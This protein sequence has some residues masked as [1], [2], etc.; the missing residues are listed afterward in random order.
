MTMMT[1]RVHADG[2]LRDG[3]D[4]D[5]G[6]DLDDGGGGGGSCGDCCDTGMVFDVVA[7][8]SSPCAT[9]HREP[10]VD[11]RVVH[12]ERTTAE[13]SDGGIR[14]SRPL[15]APPVGEGAASAAVALEDLR[16]AVE[17]ARGESTSPFQ[18]DADVAADG[19]RV[20]NPL[21]AL[22]DCA[23]E[24]LE[25]ERRFGEA[26]CAVMRG[27]SPADARLHE[28]AHRVAF[29]EVALR[30]AASAGRAIDAA[31]AVAADPA[32]CVEVDGVHVS[33]ADG[34]GVGRR[35]HVSW[36]GRIWSRSRVDSVRSGG[37]LA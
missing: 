22:A 1:T 19:H 3:V 23:I 6:I 13:G 36:W 18:D 25:A 27:V 35:R 8:T 9:C 32:P 11:P 30:T 14:P 31:V 37:D 4:G 17:R 2:G 21:V 12:W 33:G 24:Y 20:A 10:G 16:T 29:A 7:G 26:S 28:C 15:L 34:S 5:A